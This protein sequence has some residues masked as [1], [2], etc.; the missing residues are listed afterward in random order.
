MQLAT[1]KRQLTLHNLEI[2]KSLMTGKKSGKICRKITCFGKIQPKKFHFKH[3][4]RT[5]LS[6]CSSWDIKDVFR[7]PSNIYGGRFFESNSQLKCVKYFQGK[8]HLICYNRILNTF[9]IY[10]YFWSTCSNT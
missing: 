10:L 5:G 6:L 8:F 1:R 3:R 2:E 4:S 7:T 9:L